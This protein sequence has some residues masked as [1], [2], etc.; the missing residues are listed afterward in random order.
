MALP[1][2]RRCGPSSKTSPKRDGVS[3]GR[4]RTL[5]DCVSGV[6]K[7]DLVDLVGSEAGDLDRCVVEDQ[8]FE[9]DLER[10]EVPLAFFAET[11]GGEAHDVLHLLAQVFHPDAR[12]AA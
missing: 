9:L 8:L 1:Q 10:V 7:D 6:A 2:A 3:L 11:I 5:L 4:E 12:H